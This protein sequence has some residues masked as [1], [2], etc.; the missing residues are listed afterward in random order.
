MDESY[1]I[2]RVV[3]GY[4]PKDIVLE[5]ECREYLKK[6]IESLMSK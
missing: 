5:K 6:G 4:E 3:V 1:G 2:V